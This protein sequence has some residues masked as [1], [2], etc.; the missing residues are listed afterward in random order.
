MLGDRLRAGQ[1]KNTLGRF[2]L[3]AH[4]PTVPPC[5]PFACPRLAD[6]GVFGLCHVASGNG[7]T[8]RA[9]NTRY[10]PRWRWSPAHW[11]EKYNSARR[12]AHP[13]VRGLQNAS[14]VRGRR[15][16]GNVHN[17]VPAAT[18]MFGSA[19]LPGKI[20][21]TCTRA[22][23]VSRL[24]RTGWHRRT[25]ACLR[26]YPLQRASGRLERKKVACLSGFGVFGTTTW[27]T[28]RQFSG[29]A[30]NHETGQ[31]VLADP[32]NRLRT[33]SDSV[34]EVEMFRECSYVAPREADL[35]TP[36][37]LPARMR[38]LRVKEL[39]RL[40]VCICH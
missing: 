26:T 6:S 12:V 29:H 11:H 22:A 17:T 35:P 20:H 38:R 19:P 9:E 39:L 30:E 27:D 5:Q 3:H 4:C 21:K 33:L 1:H 23:R 24:K 28:D 15:V 37:P 40:G 18:M 7:M 31:R 10:R 14:D 13:A 8:M 36:S 16:S 25:V 34:R 32:G 2:R